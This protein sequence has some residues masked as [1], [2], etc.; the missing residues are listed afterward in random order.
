MI[1]CDEGHA[2][3]INVTLIDEDGSELFKGQPSNEMIW[4]VMA[5]IDEGVC[6]VCAWMSVQA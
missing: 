4:D 5:A 2:A 3:L 1:T 6:P